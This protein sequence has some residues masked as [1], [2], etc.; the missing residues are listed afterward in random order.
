MKKKIT[1]LI[2]ECKD[3]RKLELINYFIEKLLNKK[4]VEH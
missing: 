1:K 3:T 4:E 2:D